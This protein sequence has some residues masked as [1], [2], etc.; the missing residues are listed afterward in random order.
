MSLSVEQLLPG[1]VTLSVGY[2]GTRALHL[3]VF[4]DA[5]LVGQTPHGL[6]SYNVENAEGHYVGLHTPFYLPSDRSNTTL[7]SLNTG[8]SVA[9][10]WYHSMATTIRR[11]L[12][13]ALKLLVNYTWSRRWT[14]TR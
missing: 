4:I 12:I 2:V 14:M 13:T 7:G 9:N 3:P 11:P 1:K 5:N 6:R 8:F 10:S